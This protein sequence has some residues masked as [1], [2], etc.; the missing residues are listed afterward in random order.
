MPVKNNSDK[1]E[2]LKKYY[3]THK[4]EAKAYREAHKAESKAYREASKE[5]A[6]AYYKEYYKKNPE[7]KKRVFENTKK[8]Y[9]ENPGYKAEYYLKNKERASE[10]NKR[11]NKENP[12]YRRIMESK[13]R[14]RLAG[15]GGG[16]FSKIQWEEMK[17]EYN[18]I[19]PY[20]NNKKDLT[21]EHI[22]PLINNGEHDA[23]NISPACKSCNSSKG[24]KSMLF[25]MLARVNN[26]IEK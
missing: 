20:C 17:K 18:G 12:E 11:W 3:H 1:K 22:V 21:I 6:K 10:N 24:T 19:C 15:A 4:V 26:L 25:F 16:G 23:D 5:K 9:K 2:Y 13:R 8:W 7:N 14:A